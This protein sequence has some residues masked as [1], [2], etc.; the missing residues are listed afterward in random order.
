[1]TIKE[2]KK[3]KET[4]SLLHK[5]IHLLLYIRVSSTLTWHL[6]VYIEETGYKV[7]KAEKVMSAQ[8][9]LFYK[10]QKNEWYDNERPLDNQPK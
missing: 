6:N 4:L 10:P 9:F 8:T 2:K 7:T 1:M 5:L 3:L